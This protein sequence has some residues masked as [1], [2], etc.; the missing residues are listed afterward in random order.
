MKSFCIVHPRNLFVKNK[1]A[2]QDTNYKFIIG[3][4][5][6]MKISEE[7]KSKILF[8][9]DLLD[10]FYS[11][12]PWSRL[13][14]VFSDPQIIVSLRRQ[15][16]PYFSKHIDTDTDTSKLDPSDSDPDLIFFDENSIEETKRLITSTKEIKHSFF[17]IISKD[18]GSKQTNS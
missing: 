11:N 2:L 7:T 13:E 16:L 4:Q 17:L 9:N 14:S 5:D 6:V 12:L 3:F 10:A 15:M 1:A 18:A 8:S